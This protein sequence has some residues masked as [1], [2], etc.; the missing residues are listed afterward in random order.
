MSAEAI[1]GYTLLAE[2]ATWAD[3][4]QWILKWDT[5]IASTLRGNEG[6]SALREMPR[7]AI[8]Y[9]VQPMRIETQARLSAA[10]NAGMATGKCCAPTFGRA[11]WLAG[12]VAAGATVIQIEPTAWQWAV[13]D[14]LFIYTGRGGHQ[15]LQV[16]AID[17][18][19]T[20]FTLS[21]PLTASCP[22]DTAVYP[23]FFGRPELTDIEQTNGAIS[24]VTITLTG[25][26]F[27][28]DPELVPP[29]CQ[30]RYGAGGQYY[31]DEIIFMP[32]GG[33]LL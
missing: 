20:G 17:Y 13:D 18:T 25:D 33:E 21:A 8:T 30:A 19:R 27:V 5:E 15:A 14:W 28:I 6:R 12:D 26:T 2:P 4:P 11:S 22:A 7:P 24:S 16:T 3:N 23:L 29:C 10:L 1:N 9:K 31:D 32:L